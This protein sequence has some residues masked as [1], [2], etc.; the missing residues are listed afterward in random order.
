MKKEYFKSFQT[1]TNQK[2]LN[3]TLEPYYVLTP[4]LLALTWHLTENTI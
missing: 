1:K 3:K 2:F 4:L